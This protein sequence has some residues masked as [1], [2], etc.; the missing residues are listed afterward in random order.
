MLLTD[1]PRHSLDQDKAGAAAA[2]ASAERLAR[3]LKPI[4]AD[5]AVRAPRDYGSRARRGRRGEAAAPERIGCR[6]S[7]AIGRDALCYSRERLLAEMLVKE[8]S[9]LAKGNRR[10]GQ[11]VVEEILR[12]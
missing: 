3:L 11:A 1:E 10:F 9:D 8:F 12:V 5:K 2:A 4:L 6:V 7:V